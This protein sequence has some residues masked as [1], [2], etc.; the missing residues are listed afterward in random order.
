[1]ELDE[2]NKSFWNKFKVRFEKKEREQEKPKEYSYWDDLEH[3][4]GISF[5]IVFFG[6]IWL[7]ATVGM[8][9]DTYQNVTASLNISSS[10][11]Q[12]AIFSFEEKLFNI[13]LSK[14]TLFY[15]MFYLLILF[16]IYSI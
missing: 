1:M 12:K 4:F 10:L 15:Y 7:G 16:W 8:F 14:P 5:A 3:I 13:G 6:I 2:E 9:P 11:V